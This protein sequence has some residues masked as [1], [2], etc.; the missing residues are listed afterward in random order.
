MCLMLNL[1]RVRIQCSWYLNFTLLHGIFLLHRY[2]A[3]GIEFLQ[4]RSELNEILRRKRK[5]TMRDIKTASSPS[6]FAQLARWVE[7]SVE[8]RLSPGDFVA[9]PELMTHPPISLR[10]WW[11]RR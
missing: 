11:M 7:G 10:V 4:Q 6:M 2:G 9:L 5:E 1:A 8:R 3:G